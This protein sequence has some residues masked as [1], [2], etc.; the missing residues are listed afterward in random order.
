MSGLPPEA[1]ITRASRHVR[2]VPKVAN[3]NAR[4]GEIRTP[5]VA[6]MLRSPWNDAEGGL[7]EAAEQIILG[8]ALSVCAV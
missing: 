6:T 7:A 1:D 8:Y 5:F 3:Q 4:L 2:F